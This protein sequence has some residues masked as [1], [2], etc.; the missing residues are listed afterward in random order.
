MIA[1]TEIGRR[2]WLE[3]KLEAL[4]DDGFV[5]EIA[6][7][8][9]KISPKNTLKHGSIRARLLGARGEFNRAWHLGEVLDS[10]TGCQALVTR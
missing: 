8:E 6:D 1:A 9:L 5:Y 7:G 2:K 4:P 10:S 3:S